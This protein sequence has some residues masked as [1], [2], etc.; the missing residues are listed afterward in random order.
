MKYITL[1]TFREWLGQ[2][3]RANR[4][5]Q[6]YAEVMDR[7]SHVRSNCHFSRDEMNER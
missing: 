4:A 3:S 2:Y 1:A 6:E 5:R 7:L